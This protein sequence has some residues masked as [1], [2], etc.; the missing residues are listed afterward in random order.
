MLVIKNIDFV[1]SL[2]YKG[3]E[4]IRSFE[5]SYAVSFMNRNDKRTTHL[6]VTNYDCH[7][8]APYTIGIRGS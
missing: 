1:F 7:E 6:P 8:K 5:K 2:Y 4:H 3:G